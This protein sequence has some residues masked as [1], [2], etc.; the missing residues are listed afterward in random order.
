MTPRKLPLRHLG[1]LVTSAQGLGCGGMSVE[2]CEPVDDGDPVATIERALELGITLFDTAD[3]YGEGRNEELVGRTMAPYRDEVL[4]ATKVGIASTGVGVRAVDGR[5]AYA[6]S[7]CNA[8]LRRLG[9]DVI[10]LYYLHRPDPAVPIEDTVGA[11]AELV[12]AGKVRYLGLSEASA[13]TLR[14][15]QAVH[16]IAALQQAWSLFARDVE[17][18]VLPVARAVGTG[19]VAYAPGPRHPYRLGR[20]G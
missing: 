1:S 8:S 10:D 6:R 12:R 11:I 4:V 14:R 18:A 13:S 20:S 17:D 16:P 19:L 7:A 2:A 3:S 9:V 15:A 5:P